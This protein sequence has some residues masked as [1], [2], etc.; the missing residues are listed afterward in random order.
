MTCAS[1]HTYGPAQTQIRAR[2]YKG[3]GPIHFR[4]Q[5]PIDCIVGLPLPLYL[6][7]PGPLSASLS[8]WINGKDLWI[9]IKR[10]LTTGRKQHASTDFWKYRIVH[11]SQQE[12]MAIDCQLPEPTT[13]TLRIYTNP[14][15][16]PSIWARAASWLS[17]PQKN[18]F[19]L[20]AFPTYGRAR[21]LWS[22]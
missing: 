19:I 20:L 6:R 9:T 3:K 16:T 21:R 1:P 2:V 8:L 4:F 18:N 5:I 13:T 15:Q 17:P 14:S 22:S 7:S 12:G 11:K 10:L